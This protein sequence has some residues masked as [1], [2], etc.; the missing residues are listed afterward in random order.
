M[1]YSWLKVADL[2]TAQ[3]NRTTISSMGGEDSTALIV[4]TL[5]LLTSAVALGWQVVSHILS[6]ARVRCELSVAV[7]DGETPTPWVIST[8]ADRKK[9]DLSGLQAEGSETCVHDAFSVVIRNCGRA[10]VSVNRPC[11]TYGHRASRAAF[12]PHVTPLDFQMEGH[13][14]RLE[15]GEA[16]T[17]LIPM[18]E[19]VEQMRTNCPGVPVTCRATVLLGTGRWIKGR[20]ANMWTV[21]PR[22]TSLRGDLPT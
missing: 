13:M 16:K 18:W 21:P 12:G 1:A 20:R 17:W 10:A 14:C 9:T 3:Q 5:S 15:P 19:V 8:V 7:H 11:I 22:M 2:A 6:G 4:A